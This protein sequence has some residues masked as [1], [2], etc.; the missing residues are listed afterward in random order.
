MDIDIEKE[1][2][3]FRIENDAGRFPSQM[4]L[5]PNLFEFSFAEYETILHTTFSANADLLAALHKT[6]TFVEGSDI[7]EAL[8]GEVLQLIEE[9]F[10]VVSFSQAARCSVI[11]M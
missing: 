5:I 2:E 7:D 3:I 9:E 1:R 4:L 10:E 6:M 8:K 11:S